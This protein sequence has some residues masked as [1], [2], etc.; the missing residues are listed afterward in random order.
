MECI[1]IR[2]V[3]EFFRYRD[4]SAPEEGPGVH[5][6]RGNGE[7]PFFAERGLPEGVRYEFFVMNEAGKTVARYVV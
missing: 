7:I 5:V 2:H 3:T 1:S 4:G 6:D